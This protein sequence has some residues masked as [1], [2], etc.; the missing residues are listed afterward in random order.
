MK[1]LFKTIISDFIVRELDGVHTR[2]YEIPTD[3]TKIV[4]IVGARRTGKT[5]LLFSLI[6]QLRNTLSAEN[7]VYLNLE[8]DRLF[9]VSTERLSLF[10]EAYYELFPSKKN[11]LVYFFFDEVQNAPGWETFIRR[12]YD[13]EKCRIYITGSSSKL[14][15]KDLA[16]ALRGRSLSFTIYPYSFKEFLRTRS[17]SWADTYSSAARASLVNHLDQY[18]NSST[19][20]EL[21][22]FSRPLR[23]KALQ[24]YFDLII[25]KDLIE[26]YNISNH[27]L[28]KHFV[29]F[30]LV[31][32][33]NPVSITKCYNDFKSQGMAVSKNTL[34]QYQEYLADAFVI[35]PVGMYTDNLREKN[36]NYK[37]VYS[38]DIGLNHLFSNTY[39][40]GRI[41]ENI[42]FLELCRRY[43][44]IQY[45][46]GTQEVDF[47]AG[48][49]DSIHLFNVA[50]DIQD[51]QTLHREVNG[52]IEAMKFMKKKESYLIT[53]Y[54]EEEISTGEMKIHIIPLWKWLIS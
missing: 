36:R 45:F 6:K 25:Y 35:F 29:R 26:R 27:V 24:D 47:I 48:D 11:E 32:M 9:P 13:T 7:I 33:S 15:S 53:G 30:L 2:D 49:Y 20:P 1:E 16:T 43:E 41:Y 50:F 3:I 38:V 18:L 40:T 39:T 22:D 31:N 44:T 21:I 34:F 19:F 28:I 23:F 14:L 8:D 4:S 10:I 5:Y 37:K 52:L 42:V 51:T 54:K 17:Q 12:I 46:K